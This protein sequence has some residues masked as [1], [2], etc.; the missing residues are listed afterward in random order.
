[1]KTNAEGV[2]HI[3]EKNKTPF[4]INRSDL[5]VSLVDFQKLNKIYMMTFNT[6]KLDDDSYR[7]FLKG[8]YLTLI[9]SEPKVVSRPTYIH[10]MSWH[11]FAHSNYEVFKSVDVWLPGNN[12]YL[13]RHYLLP[14]NE[15]LR[16]LLGEMPQN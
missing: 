2:T 6:M 5:E 12:F 7:V 16:V 11:S 13:I 1:M 9:I 14:G 4:L 15:V 8:H 10:N 3:L